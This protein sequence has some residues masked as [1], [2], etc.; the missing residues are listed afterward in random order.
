MKQTKPLL[1][2]HQVKL[3]QWTSQQD[4][5]KQTQCFT[6]REL[7]TATNNFRLESMTGHGGFGSVFKGKLEFPPGQFKNVAVKMLDTTGHQGDKEFLVEVL[8]LS[9]LRH[10][11]LVTLFGYCAEGEESSF[12][13]IAKRGKLDNLNPRNA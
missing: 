8:M 11:H 4:P 10:E 2:F 7:A 5:S 6:Y 1:K 12:K 3:F 13:L 9:L